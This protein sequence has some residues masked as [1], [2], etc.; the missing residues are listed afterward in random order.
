MHKHINVIFCDEEVKSKQFCHPAQ[1][2]NETL[3][4]CLCMFDSVVSHFS[5]VT[6]VGPVAWQNEMFVRQTT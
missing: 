2:L 4:L 1:T 6:F 5:V 3:I